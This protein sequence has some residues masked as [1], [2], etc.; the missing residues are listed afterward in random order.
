MYSL[1]GSHSAQT[2][3]Q[4][5]G[6]MLHLLEGEV[7]HKLVGILLYGRIVCSPPFI[8]LFSHL[9]ISVWTQGYLFYPLDYNPIIHYL[10]CC[11]DCSSLW[12]LGPLSVG[13][14]FLCQAPSFVFLNTSLFFG[15]TKCSRLILYIPCPTPG[16]SHPSRELW[17][18]YFDS[19]VLE[20]DCPPFRGTSRTLIKAVFVLHVIYILNQNIPSIL[21]K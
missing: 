17:L 15:T 14:L 18:M 21:Q 11:S 16:I 12:P 19:S 4:G 8:Y 3:L 10:F 2:T 9:F 6:V 5:L 1:E 20:G 13:S 7:S